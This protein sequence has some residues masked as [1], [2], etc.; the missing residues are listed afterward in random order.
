[1]ESMPMNKVK[2][3]FAI[4]ALSF[5]SA[6]ASVAVPLAAYAGEEAINT[7]EGAPVSKENSWRYEDGEPIVSSDS[8]AAC[9]DSEDDGIALQSVGTMPS[10]VTA[11]GIDVSGWQGNIDW[12]A[13]KNSGIDFAILKIGNLDESETDGWYTDS[14]F[15]R[16]MTECERLGIPYGVY[17]Y[18][19][20]KSTWAYENGADHIISLLKGH[21]PSLPVY[22]DLEDD[23]INP[24]K[25]SITK[26]QLLQFSRAFCDRISA[27]G[28][29]PGVYSGAGWFKNYLTD[30]AYTSGEWSVW[31]AQYPYGSKYMDC[32]SESESGEYPE[33]PSHG[34]YDFWQYS[35]LANVSGISGHVDINYCY[36]DLS[37]SNSSSG[38]ITFSDV[39]SDTPHSADI[40]WLGENGISTGWAKFGG[41]RTFQPYAKIAR[42]DMAAF[43]YRL[44]GSPDYEAPSVSPFKDVN[45]STSHYKEICWLASQGI[46]EGWTEADGTKTFRPYSNTARADMA[47]FLY[48]LAKSPQYDESS[49]TGFSEVDSSTPHY[50]EICWL[51]SA[52]ISTGWNESDGSMTFRAWNN[53][54]RADMAAFLH[55]MRNAGL[56]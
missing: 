33:Y 52:G 13:V 11:R 36:V 41:R 5:A 27:A 31:V 18:A 19:Y 1:M 39:N 26:Q 15:V 29:Y 43:L 16:N 20:G 12:Q 42:A 35:S 47:A 14:C 53:I 6:T 4:L 25:S 2:I 3:A 17:V 51:Y 45:A 46:S 56:A 40:V 34:K 55:R 21:H 24:G 23:T 38:S 7:S 10:N 54:A 37:A 8:A 44:A 32:I 49:F 48:R 22:L 50:K 28:Y 30:S 9:S